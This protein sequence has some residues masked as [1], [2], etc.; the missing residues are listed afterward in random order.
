VHLILI[1]SYPLILGVAS[2]GDDNRGPALPSDFKGLLL[3]SGLGLLS[4]FVVFGLGWLA[5]R[6]TRDQLLL[7]W[8]PGWWV[9]PLGLGYSVGIRLVAGLSLGILFAIMVVTRII[10]A[11][12]VQQFVT[13][14][15]PQ[16]EAVVDV[17]AL[18][19]NP[20]YFWFTIT[21]VSFVVAGLREELWRAGFLAGMAALWPGAFGSKFGQL[22]AVTIGA[23]IFGLG[24]LPMG[25]L[26]VVMTGAVGFCLGLIMVLHRSIWPAVIA[27]GFFDATTFAILP[28][29]KELL[30]TTQKSLG[31]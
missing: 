12:E 18:S 8:R 26:A 13:D 10:P 2:I 7:R 25:M 19:E 14:N 24:H 22:L 1:G 6:A 3:A 29:V 15:R 16:I 27:H 9:L 11:A 17:E 21:V 20:A 4:F 28:W 30:E 31:Q 23:I 5:S